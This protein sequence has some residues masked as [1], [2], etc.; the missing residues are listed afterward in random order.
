MGKDKPRQRL[1][2]FLLRDVSDFADAL[3]TED[4]DHPAQQIEVLAG[5]G[6]DARF[7]WRAKSGRTPDWLKFLAPVLE[8]VPT[9]HMASSSGLLVLRREGHFFA[10]TFGYGRSMLDHSKVVHRFGL[11]VALNTIDPAQ[12]RSLDT[13][14]Y[15]EL[16]VAKNTQASRSTGLST[17]DVDTV[18]DILRNVT[19]GP[20]EG[21][22][23]KRISGG[24]SVVLN[25]EALPGDLGRICSDL[26]ASYRDTAYKR[27]FGWVDDLAI[28][29]DRALV[30]ELDDL[31]VAQLRAGDTSLTHMAMPDVLEWQEVDS[32]KI[33]P[34]ARQ[35]QFEDLDLD[36]YLAWLP[37]REALTID[38][39]RSRAV[40][41]R[42]ARSQEWHR[43]WNVYQCLVS[44]QR[45]AEGLFALIEGQWYAI[46][47]NLAQ[48]V[49][50]YAATLRAAPFELPAGYVGEHEAAYNERLAAVDP[51]A[52]LCLDAKI[53]RP[54][55]ASSGIEVCDVLLTDGTLVHVKRKS[56]SS[57]MSHLFA[58]GLI[59]I[60]TLL[61][62]GTF[63]NRLR[64][65]IAEQVD[66]IDVWSQVV[67]DQGDSPD[68]AYYSVAYVVLANSTREGSDWLPFFSKLNLM[69]AAKTLRASIGVDVTLTRV[70]LIE[71][72]SQTTA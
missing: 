64:E 9:I 39:L 42:F 51:G 54:D 34:V 56:R 46:S 43:Q 61:A 3:D 8:E 38:A 40:Q 52:R 49:D 70:D 5:E 2:V 62:E 18:R 68:R 35:A 22:L 58:Q 15:D 57:T 71:R 50:T 60:T 21:T 1:N 25:I 53:L 24:D 33:A 19:G 67:P 23:G 27:D 26:L 41:V 44:E 69:Q 11:R 14:T 30:D 63:R 48:E 65:Y 37:D 59:S 31:L 32:F 17:F 12:I 7:Y 36:D 10:L 20:R 6:L 47:E 29:D 55:G 28:V 72:P 4:S 13:K 16:V 66:D 45:T